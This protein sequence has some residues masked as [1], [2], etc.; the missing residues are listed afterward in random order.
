[1]EKKRMVADSPEKGAIR[2]QVFKSVIEKYNDAMAKGF[3]LEAVTLMES[4]IGDRL[5]SQ[6][7]YNNENGISFAPLGRLTNPIENG[8]LVVSN[9]IKSVI[10]RIK[11]WAKKRN[12]ALH[13]IAKIADSEQDKT[14]ED[15][16]NAAK[17]CAE[18]GMKIFRELDKL[19]K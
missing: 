6:I 5:E 1:M 2:Q 8:K 4:M 14:F 12:A 7:A 11:E 15:K 9:A 16:Y 19:I 13:E 17:L 10:P 3:Y 18:E